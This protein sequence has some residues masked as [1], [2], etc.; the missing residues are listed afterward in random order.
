MSCRLIDPSTCTYLSDSG[1][2]YQEFSCLYKVLE[3]FYLESEKCFDSVTVL[4]WAE[5]NPVYPIAAVIIYGV[6]I[7]SGQRWMKERQAFSW[8]FAMGAW[9]LLL[10]VFSFGC[11]VRVIPHM[12]HNLAMGEPRDILCTSPEK[13]YGYGSTGLWITLFVLSKFAELIDTVFIVAHK[14]PLMVLHWYHHMSVLVWSWYAFVTRTP[15]SVIFLSMNASVHTLMYGYYF[16]MTMKIKPAW[17]KAKVITIVQ[18]VQMGIGLIATTVSTYYDQTQTEDKPCDI[19]P[20][21]LLPCYAM[22]ASYFVLFLHFF[23][24][25]Y[26]QKKRV[27]G[28]KKL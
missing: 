6:V 8:K 2:E 22:Y 18:L 26:T 10:C 21:S 17:L 11:M 12:M 7:Y 25:R 20:G 4:N 5:D 13:T 19:R 27:K 15:S 16:L 23:T 1:V 14:K 24:G 28:E 9:N 3:P